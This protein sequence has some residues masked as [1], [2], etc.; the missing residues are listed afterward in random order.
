MVEI[1]QR[2][3]IMAGS[4]AAN[5][6]SRLKGSVPK[7]GN[8]LRITA[9]RVNVTDGYHLWSETF[10]RRMEDVFAVQDE[11]AQTIARALRVV[12]TE[13]EKRALA[14]APTVKVQACEYYLR[15]RQFF[16]Q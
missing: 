7:A 10:D 14:K 5:G 6:Q 11:I 2:F 3:G 9:Q 12:L 8:R 13:K 15:G 1:G 16:H 4:E